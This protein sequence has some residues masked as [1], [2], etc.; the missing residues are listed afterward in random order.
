MGR[1][2]HV[3]AF[4][5]LTIL[6][7][8][9]AVAG[10]LENQA[11][12]SADPEEICAR[13]DWTEVSNES[14]NYRFC[15]PGTWEH[16]DV[17]NFEPDVFVVPDTNAT[18]RQLPPSLQVQTDTVPDDQTPRSYAERNLI[19]PV[20]QHPDIELEEA[21]ETEEPPTI[22]VAYTVSQRGED[23]YW[24]HRVLLETDRVHMLLYRGPPDAALSASQTLDDV[25]TTFTT[26][27]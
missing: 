1:L 21:R 4:A 12:A 9:A 7:A 13:E 6:V 8:L 24:R 5:G 23:A 2:D 20:S 11:S 27:R 18:G 19:P 10:C 26:A 3:G 14:E 22:Y 15:H 16:R 17:R 25:F